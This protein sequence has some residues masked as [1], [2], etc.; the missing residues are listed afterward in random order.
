VRKVI[1]TEK[2]SNGKRKNKGD[3]KAEGEGVVINKDE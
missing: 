2:I 3:K 1:N